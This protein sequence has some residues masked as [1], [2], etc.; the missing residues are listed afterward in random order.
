MRVRDEAP[1]ET[2][3]VVVKV[4]VALAPSIVLERVFVSHPKLTYCVCLVIGAVA[5][6]FVPP[7]GTIKQLLILVGCAI[8]LGVAYWAFF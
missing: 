7:R 3:T 5:S 1:V 4:L 8:I 2:S 6:Y